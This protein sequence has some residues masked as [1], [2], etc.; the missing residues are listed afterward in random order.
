MSENKKKYAYWLEP[1]LVEEM[2]SM[3]RDANATSKGDFIRQSI[4]FY[5]A[6]LRQGK[7]IDFISSLLAQTIKS[8]IESVEQNLSEMMFKVAVEQAVSS[9]VIAAFN[10]VDDETMGRLRNTCSNIVA[11][12][13]GVFTFEDAYK[14]QKGDD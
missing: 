11:S 5:M 6:Y 9:Q 12:T 13:N 2:E 3:L 14:F 4:N 10:N 1:S 7:S 8:E